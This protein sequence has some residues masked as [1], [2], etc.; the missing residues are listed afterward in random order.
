MEY[1]Q[2]NTSQ[3]VKINFKK[4]GIGLRMLAFTIDW[5]IKI[6]FLLLTIYLLSQSEFMI[7]LQIND[8]WSYNGVIIILFLPIFFYSL[9][10]ETLLE[11]QTPGKRIAKIKVIKIDGYQG[12]F[13][14]YFIRWLFTLVDF[15]FSMGIVA[16]TSIIISKKGQRLGDL[17]AGTTLINLRPETTLKYTILEEIENDYVIRFPN[18]ILLSDRDIQIIKSQYQN[19]FANRDYKLIHQLAQKISEVTQTHQGNMGDLQYIK[20]ILKDY[21]HLTSKENNF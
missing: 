20:T 14:D 4:A 18:A 3:N 15:F 11:G 21:N 6:S 9:I 16:V 7:R 1:I 13:S 12:Y 2:I 8:S 10:F 5:L 19:A 17:A